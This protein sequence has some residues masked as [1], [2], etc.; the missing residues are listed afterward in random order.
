MGRTPIYERV[1]AQDAAEGRAARKS[2]AGRLLKAGVVAAI[3][4]LYIDTL[5][6]AL[7]GLILG[8]WEKDL[9]LEARKISPGGSRYYLINFGLLVAQCFLIMGI[10][11]VLRTK[12]KTRVRTVLAASLLCWLFGLMPGIQF[13]NSGMISAGLLAYRFSLG[14]VGLVPAVLAG[15][16]VIETD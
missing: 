3:I 7:I 11:P 10:Y 6:Q 14:L 15:S 8:V 9:L 2:A 12:L 1:N 13:L 16:L 5:V 4:S